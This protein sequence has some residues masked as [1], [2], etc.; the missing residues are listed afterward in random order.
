MSI[1][2]LEKVWDIE[3]F[4]TYLIQKNENKMPLQKD[5]GSKMTAL[6][7]KAH[8]HWVKERYFLSKIRQLT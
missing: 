1:K 4:V 2:N 8:A 6:K 3:K 5:F 7:L